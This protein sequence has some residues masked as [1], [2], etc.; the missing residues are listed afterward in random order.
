MV[1]PV[2]LPTATAAIAA[3]TA[4]APAAKLPPHRDSVDGTAPGS[5][6]WTPQGTQGEAVGE[7]MEK[8]FGKWG[9]Q[10]RNSLR[11]EEGVRSGGIAI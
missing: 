5:G 4:T 11:M 3:R 7:M 8:Q 2:I 6:T 9:K 10:S 1:N